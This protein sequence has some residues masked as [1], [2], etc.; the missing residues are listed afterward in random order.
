MRKGSKKRDNRGLT[1]VELI[2]AISISTILIGAAWQFVLTGT[3]SYN[4]QKSKVDMQMEVQQTMNQIENLVVD[5]NRSIAYLV[6]ATETGND[7]Q[8]DESILESASTKTINIY[9]TEK[10]S[11]IVWQKDE[12]QVVY[13]ELMVSNVSEEEPEVVENEDDSAILAENVTAFEADLTKVNTNNVVTLK[14][15]FEKNS[16]VYEAERN[17]T[18]RNTVMNTANTDEIYNNEDEQLPIS[19]TIECKKN[20]EKD[21]ETQI[22]KMN[23]RDTAEFVATVLGT[24]DKDVIWSVKGNTS[25]GTTIDVKT[26]KLTIDASEE[27]GNQITIIASLESNRSLK[28]L[29]KILVEEVRPSIQLALKDNNPWILAGTSYDTSNKDCPIQ[30]KIANANEERYTLKAYKEY[31]TETSAL[32]FEGV[33]TRNQV[34]LDVLATQEYSLVTNA[35]VFYL[36]A[37]LNENP[38]IKSN[39]IEMKIRKPEFDIQVSTEDGDTTQTVF[40][41][42]Q[43]LVLSA[44]WTKAATIDVDEIYNL[45]KPAYNLA[46]MNASKLTW[47]MDYISSD[48]QR[49]TEIINAN[50]SLNTITIPSDIANEGEGANQITIYAD[51]RAYNEEKLRF[52]EEVYDI[53][54]I[55]VAP[56]QLSFEV[57]KVENAVI[58]DDI[59]NRGDIVEFTIQID[60]YETNRRPSISWSVNEGCPLA[61]SGNNGYTNSIYVNNTVNGSPLTTDEFDITVTVV[62][63]NTNASAQYTIHIPKFTECGLD[64][65]TTAKY[66]LYHAK[67]EMNV[68]SLEADNYDATTASVKK[69]IGNM[70]NSESEFDKAFATATQTGKIILQP[71]ANSGPNQLEMSNIPYF[72]YHVDNKQSGEHVAGIR[73]IPVQANFKVDDEYICVP[74]A[75]ENAM[76]KLRGDNNKYEKE[77]EFINYYGKGKSE[78]DVHRYKCTYDY[79]DKWLFV[80]WTECKLTITDLYDNS[81]IFTRTYRW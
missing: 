78:G 44:D 1:L 59:V 26:G 39:I 61:L 48:G 55:S 77:Y 72:D 47:A 38:E 8:V 28:G 70:A 57:P 23:Q 24:D 31:P 79:E 42:G 81:S 14:L 52:G 45:Q 62:D 35:C 36:Q 67:E 18:L 54:T 21:E 76:K 71:R 51:S 30:V 50:T 58:K 17:I 4:S 49:H 19:I 34:H 32:A 63:A 74:A 73:L 33:Q 3:K 43:E 10:I 27:K 29:K 6:D 56:V 13:K 66:Y 25:A 60:G 68:I 15:T 22:E 20:L 5:A 75:D 11:Q 37:E 7:A 41:R 69:G 80:S 9:G 46:I 2:V 12:K 16:D 65:A 40:K 64:L 53:R